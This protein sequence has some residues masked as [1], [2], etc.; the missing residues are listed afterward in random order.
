MAFL[1]ASL[2][3]GVLDFGLSVVWDL[4]T[5]GGTHDSTSR[6]PLLPSLL[7]FPLPRPPASTWAFIIDGASS[8]ILIFGRSGSWR[9]WCRLT[10]HRDNMLGLLW[11]CD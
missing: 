11:G 2:G 5:W 10:Y 8:A 6:T 1:N 4:D 3:L 9:G 7:N